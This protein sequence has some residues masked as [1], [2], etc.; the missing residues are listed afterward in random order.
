MNRY[1]ERTT[2]IVQRPPDTIAIADHD[3]VRYWPAERNDTHIDGAPGPLVPFDG[4]MGRTTPTSAHS[5]NAE[6]Q[7]R[8]IVRLAIAYTV[9]GGMIT[10]GL[11]ILAR[12]A[13]IVGG[14]WSLWVFGILAA[15]GAILLVALLVN[16]ATAM[17]YSGEGTERHRIDAQADVM[18]HA[19]DAHCEL[20]RERWR[21]E[22]GQ[23]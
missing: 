5:G 3:G 16:Q 10:L 9:A 18:H 13:G 23:W 8:A 20:V 7:A 19:I 15:W 6:I 11:F 4:M 17:R 14:R 2:A 22:R 1:N 12:L 21:H